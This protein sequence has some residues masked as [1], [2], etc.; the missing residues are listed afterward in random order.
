MSKTGSPSPPVL[1]PALASTVSSLVPLIET[2]D[3]PAIK[4]VRDFRYIHTY[5]SKV[6]ASEPVLTKPSLVDG[7]PPL[8]T[9]P[10]DLDIPIALRKSKRS[11]TGHLISNFIS[12]D[13]LNPTFR[14]LPYHGLLSLYPDLIQRLYWYL[15]GNRLWMRR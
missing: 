5:R 4:P 9:S 6:P 2:Q 7:P 11:C 8:S 10:S 14:H 3:P 12:Y 15:P 13:H 1:L